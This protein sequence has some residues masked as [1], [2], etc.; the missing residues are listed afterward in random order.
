MSHDITPAPKGA[1][2]APVLPLDE[3]KAPS[4][5]CQRIP[6]EYRFLT[7]DSPIPLSWHPCAAAEGIPGYCTKCAKEVPAHG[8]D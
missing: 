6:G 1:R 8:Q 5:V 4:L 2:K 3:R 7:P